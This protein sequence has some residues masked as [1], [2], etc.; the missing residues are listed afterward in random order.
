MGADPVA[1]AKSSYNDVEHIFTTKEATKS[2]K[3]KIA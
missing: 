3:F 2:T 1:L